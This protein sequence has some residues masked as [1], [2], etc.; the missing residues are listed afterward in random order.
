[1][2][3]SMMLTDLS[4]PSISSPNCFSLPYSGRLNATVHQIESMKTQGLRRD[5]QQV[6]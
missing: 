6:T 2:S 3:C 4:R 5:R 1:M